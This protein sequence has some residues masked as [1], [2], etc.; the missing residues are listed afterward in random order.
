MILYTSGENVKWYNHSG[1]SLQFHR[2]LSIHISFVPAI[3]LIVIYPRG[4][5]AYVDTI[6]VANIQLCPCSTKMD[7]DYMYANELQRVPIKLYLWAKKKVY[8]HIRVY[9]I[10]TNV[11]NTF[12]YNGQNLKP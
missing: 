2:R 9:N 1:N 6:S 3:P 10:Y 7:R 5:K 11:Q 8:V 12:I 4:I